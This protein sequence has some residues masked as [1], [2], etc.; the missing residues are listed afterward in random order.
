MTRDE[1][2]ENSPFRDPVKLAEAAAIY[3]RAL[4]RPDLIRDEQDESE[5][6][7][8]ERAS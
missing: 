6:Q 1:L 3:R 4:D 7:Q 8:Q 5:A 2:P